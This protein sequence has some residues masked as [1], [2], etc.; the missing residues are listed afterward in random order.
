MLVAAAVAVRLGRGPTLLALAF[1]QGPDLGL[2]EATVAAWRPDAADATRRG[3]P[4]H[5]LG[6]DAEQRGHLARRQETISTVHGPL[7]AS[8]KSPA[9]PRWPSQSL[10]WDV[11]PLQHREPSMSDKQ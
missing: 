7:L 6:I 3:P 2:A 4:G 8:T 11:R 10:R 9:P 1:E 5:G